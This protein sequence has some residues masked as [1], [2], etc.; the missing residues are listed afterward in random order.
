VR[1]FNFCGSGDFSDSITIDVSTQPEQMTP[2]VL[3]I[4][5]CNM[6]F[7]WS[8]PDDGSSPLLEYY[9][10]AQDSN[11]EWKHLTQCGQNVNI[12]TCSIEMAYF[13]DGNEFSL[14]QG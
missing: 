7:D 8:R 3:S 12:Q 6:R 10:E 1:K 14:S 13:T 11:G 4:T 2:P 9:V 5:G